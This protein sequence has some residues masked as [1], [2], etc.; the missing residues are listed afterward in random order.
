MIPFLSGRSLLK[1][2]V[3]LI[4]LWGL[5]ALPLW[6]DPPPGYYDSVDPSTSETL[7]S[8]LH[9]VID[10]HTKIPYTSG[11][12]DTWDVLELADEDPLDSGKILD[13]YRNRSTTKVGG[14]TSTYN[15]EHTW[16]KGYGFPDDGSTN[17][18]YTDCHHLFLCDAIYNA[19]RD[20]RVYEYCTF[21]CNSYVADTYNG[22][23]G[24]NLSQ[25]Y[26]PVGVWET[27]I[28]RRGDVAR[29]QLYMDVRYEGGGVE[30]DLILT[31]SVDLILA[32]AT[33]NNESVA[34]MGMLQTLLQWHEEDPVDDK[35]RN[36]NDV[37]YTYQGNRNPFID[38]PEWVLGV[39]D[40]TATSIESDRPTAP[41]AIARSSIS[42]AFPNPF[43]PST[44]IL[45]TV[46]QSGHVQVDLFSVTGKRVRTLLSES[47]APGDYQVRWNG[48]SDT[49]DPVTS[50]L[51]FCRLQS[52]GDTDIR[53]LILLK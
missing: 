52:G 48:R 37:V 45:F 53:K 51:Y 38:H 7:R 18:P 22:E 19:T 44:N 28:G 25:V 21:A 14:G 39:F 35:E 26:S 31:D 9:D 1:P 10:G 41:A 4:L 47:R 29:A 33:G 8:T 24:T 23:S 46:G 13:V 5:I 42:S 34:Y 15:R 17:F 30:P 20:T 16:P 2:A 12:T 6:A 36:R 50:G 40:P 3:Q 27:W 32:S 43:N 49:G 11:S